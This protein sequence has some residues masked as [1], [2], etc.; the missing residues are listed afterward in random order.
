[1][2]RSVVGLDIGGANL[3]AAHVSGRA[4]SQPFALWKNPAGLPDALRTLL[5]QVPAFDSLSVTMTG[6]L[7]DCFETKRQGVRTI[8]D[9]VAAVAGSTPVKVWQTDGRFVDLAA[10]HE[11]PLLAAASNW[12]ALATFVGRFAPTGHALL[13]DIGSTTTDIIPLRD[14]KPVPRGR[15]DTDRLR[16]HE[17]IYTGIR[18]TPL[19]ALLGSEG[20]A[21][22]FA[23]TQDVYLVLHKLS[24]NEANRD[25]ADGRPATRAFAHARLARMICGDVESSTEESRRGLA[26]R[27]CNRQTLLIR[28]AIESMARAMS[29]PLSAVILAGSGEFLA[30]GAMESRWDPPTHLPPAERVI[31]LTERLGKEISDAACAHALAVLASEADDGK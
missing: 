20:A 9:A 25:T 19:C 30:R 6:E 1:V 15:T 27:I 8:L 2:P 11:H 21:E 23:T 4:V 13:I 14:G 5:Q 10:S 22:L 28:Q 3:K 18:R 26:L 17:L 12:L 7:C 31:S 29:G 16:Y 24:E